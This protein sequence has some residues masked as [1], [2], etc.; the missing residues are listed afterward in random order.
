MKASAINLPS[1][2]PI[3]ICV[4]SGTDYDLEPRQTGYNIKKCFE[5][6]NEYKNTGLLISFYQWLDDKGIINPEDFKHVCSLF[7]NQNCFIELSEFVKKNKPSIPPRMNI[8]A[9]KTIMRKH[10]FIFV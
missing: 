2:V 4:L 1:S 7:D 10:K 9:I 8:P 5:L 6:F 3:K